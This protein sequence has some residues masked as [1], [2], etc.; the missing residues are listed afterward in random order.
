M[1]FRQNAYRPA[2]L[3]NQLASKLGAAKRI[4][5]MQEMEGASL[6]ALS[7]TPVSRGGQNKAIYD[8]LSKELYALEIKGSMRTPA[9]Q[10]RYEQIIDI[11]PEYGPL[12]PIASAV[13]NQMNQDID[14]IVAPSGYSWD[15]LSPTPTRPS[16]HFGG[17]R[18]RTKRVKRV[19]RKST[20]R[21]R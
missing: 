19:K 3:G 21:R 4:S 5:A 18:R 6:P 1:R 17:A 14:N 13:K 20:H 16:T 7:T 11:L 2:R 10:A 8:R 15:S 12:G 9:E